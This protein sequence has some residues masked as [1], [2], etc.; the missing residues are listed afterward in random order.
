MSTGLIRGP[1]PKTL[2][3][4]WRNGTQLR[5]RDDDGFETGLA[6]ELCRPRSVLVVGTLDE[7]V[8]ESGR[9]NRS[10]FRSFENF[11]RSLR[12][13]EIVTFDEVYHRASAVLDLDVAR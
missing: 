5:T 6:L 1:S 7:M 10:R 8:N 2:P 13:P 9:P 4:A 3:A 12:D 11:R